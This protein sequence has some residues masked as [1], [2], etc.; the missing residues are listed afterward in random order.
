MELVSGRGDINGPF[1]RLGVTV[2]VGD[3]QP[4]LV[5]PELRQLDTGP[6]AQR[7]IHVAR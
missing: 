3:D 1:Q 6:I 4:Q 5:A 7:A 2:P